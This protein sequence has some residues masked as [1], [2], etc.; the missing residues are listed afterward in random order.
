MGMEIE[1]KFLVLNEDWKVGAVGTFLHQ[2]YLNRHPQRSVRVR[3]KGQQAVLTIKGMVSEIS[4][5]E[6]EY[7]VPLADAEHMLKELCEPPTLEKT[8]YLVECEEMCWEIDEFHGDNAGL[9]VAEIELENEEQP[10][11]KPPWL[12]EEVSRDPRYLNINLSQHPYC[13][14]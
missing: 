12:G 5:F 4:R 9:V 13:Q 3:V 11:A 10:F 14:W 6:Y 7:P 2:G 8:R 1:R